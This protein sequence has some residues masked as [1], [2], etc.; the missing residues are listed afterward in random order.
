MA[1]Q[2]TTHGSERLKQ[3]S[4]R[5][6]IRDLIRDLDTATASFYCIVVG[7][8]DEH[9]RLAA[10]DDEISAFSI[11]HKDEIAAI[12]SGCQETIQ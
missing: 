3:A 9:G 12:L 1:L 11:S 2:F 10:T 8:A 5:N 4:F 7:C 6:Q